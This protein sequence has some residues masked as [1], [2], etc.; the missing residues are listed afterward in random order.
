[1]ALKEIFILSVVFLSLSLISCDDPEVMAV[2][3]YMTELYSTNENCDEQDYINLVFKD[4]TIRYTDTSH[5]FYI[6]EL[7]KHSGG[8]TNPHYSVFWEDEINKKGLILT[9]FYTG[10][11]R[12]MSDVFLPGKYKLAA[13]RFFDQN[14]FLFEYYPSL[15]SRPSL[16]SND[17]SGTIEL[18]G[19]SSTFNKHYLCGN[20]QLKLNSLDSIYN[21]IKIDGEFRITMPDLFRN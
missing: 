5:S 18:T 15:Y 17:E 6:G 7:Q 9:F 14:G 20:F 13:S 10:D 8:N 3:D 4:S 21:G 12:P 19:V 11:E 1:M 2:P 16:Y